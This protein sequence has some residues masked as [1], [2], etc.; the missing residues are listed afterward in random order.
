MNAALSLRL[1]DALDA[2]H[3]ALV[4]KPGVGALPV[5]FEHDLLEPANSC[6]AGRYHLGLPVTVVGVAAVHAIEIGCE[7]GSLVATCA[8]ADLYDDVT[9]VPRVL[10]Q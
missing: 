6:L 4:L 3:A 7:Q 8:R 1:G 5:H 10:R 9:F 2:M